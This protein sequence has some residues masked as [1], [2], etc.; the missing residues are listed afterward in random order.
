[1]VYDQT[2]HKVRFHSATIEVEGVPVAWLPAV[3][4]PDPTVRYAS[5]LLTPEVGNSTK[6]GYFTR[7]P[8]Y[9]A[10]I[11]KPGHDA[12]ADVLHPGRRSAGDG[13]SRP[14]EQ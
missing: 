6:I 8:V 14:L 12:G 9:V 11:A 10:L 1:M 13:I 7:L 5:G 3:S 4:V 2:K